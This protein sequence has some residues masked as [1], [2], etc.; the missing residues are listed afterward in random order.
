M[1]PTSSGRQGV[2]GTVRFAAVTLGKHL[3]RA[4]M[5]VLRPDT[6]YSPVALAVRCSVA[7]LYLPL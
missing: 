1:S 6:N 4:V 3:N 2:A 7:C 5:F